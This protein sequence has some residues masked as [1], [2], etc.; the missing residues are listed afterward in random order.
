MARRW[1]IR[2]RRGWAQPPEGRPANRGLEKAHPVAGGPGWRGLGR[3]AAH[4][5]ASTSANK[6]IT[7]WSRRRRAWS[8]MSLLTGVAQRRCASS[9]V[10]DSSTGRSGVDDPAPVGSPDLDLAGLGPLGDWD[11]QAQHT[12]LV[13]RVDPLRVEILSEYQLP[14]EHPALAF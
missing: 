4:K 13:G 8:D 10:P 11:A 12:V 14:T 1:W 9:Q 7:S 3:S 5:M 2:A 6:S